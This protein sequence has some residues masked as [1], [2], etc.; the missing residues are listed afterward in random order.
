M[1]ILN[2]KNSDTKRSTAVRG[3]FKIIVNE[4]DLSADLVHNFHYVEGRFQGVNLAFDE[5]A[6]NLICHLVKFVHIGVKELA[7]A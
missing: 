5:A 3:L 1:S 2:Y 7:A 6:A 4:A